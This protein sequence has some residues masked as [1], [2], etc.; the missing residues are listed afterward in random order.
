MKLPALRIMRQTGTFGVMARTRWRQRRLVIL[1]YHGVSIDDEHL[2]DSSLYISAETL[3]DSLETVRR[4]GCTVLPLGEAFARLSRGDLPP[5]AVSLTFDD[6]NADFAL[7]AV[8]VLRD[9]EYPATVFV[10][11]YYCRVQRPVF[12]PACRYILWKSPPAVLD[13]A[14]IVD[15]PAPLST[16]SE[17]DREAAFWRI[18]RFV[19]EQGCSGDAKHDLLQELA[20]RL[21]F[22]LDSLRRSR[23]FYLMDDNEMSRLPTHL[24]DVQLHT[25]RH[26]TPLDRELFLREIEENRGYLTDVLGGD[27]RFSHF[28]YPFGNYASVFL[29]W[30]AEARMDLATTTDIGLATASH[31]PLLLP[32]VA[33]TS[34]ISRVELQAWL[35]GVRDLLPV[36][37]RFR[38]EHR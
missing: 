14:G 30:L 27:R 18:F 31:D 20:S 23:R 24:A 34:A 16:T 4:A 2:C 38:S 5:R 21:S 22:D 10:S 29:P 19:R 32:R 36:R 25:H 6:G 37:R 13:P 12:P 3:R 28:C 9:F 7:R 35:T 17:E 11:T 26:R 1:M 33:L 8:P 15:G